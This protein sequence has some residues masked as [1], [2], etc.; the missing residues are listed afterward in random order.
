MEC[1]QSK[2]MQMG[3]R[4]GA[5]TAILSFVRSAADLD[6]TGAPDDLVVRVRLRSHLF[7]DLLSRGTVH[8][9]DGRHTIEIRRRCCRKGTRGRMI[10]RTLVQ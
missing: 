2:C 5:T 1:F 7:V 8:T 3:L 6:A 10:A 9:V 4:N